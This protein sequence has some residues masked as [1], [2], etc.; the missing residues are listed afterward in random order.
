MLAPKI[1]IRDLALEEILRSAF[2]TLK[3]ECGGVV[4]GD[5][6][7]KKSCE[8]YVISSVHPFQLAGRNVSTLDPKDGAERSY[9]SFLQESIGEFHSH[10]SGRRQ[11]NYKRTI[12]IGRVHM[13][14]EDK[15]ALKRDKNKTEIVVAW[16]EVK[17]KGVLSSENPYLVSGYIENRDLYRGI[18][19]FD[20]GAYIHNGRL[21]RCPVVVS[22]KMLRLLQN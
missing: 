11:L 6:S 3:V 7:I 9:L 10:P 12:D 14:G 13:S 15:D 20:M 8:T 16:R 18:L 19:R 21:R 1:V 5:R 22:P 4:F 2:E 17:Q